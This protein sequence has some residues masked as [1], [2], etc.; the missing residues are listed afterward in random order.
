MHENEVKMVSKMPNGDLVS[1]KDYRL[2]VTEA[3]ALD[4][5]A[6]VDKQP[7]NYVFALI[8]QTERQTKE[9]E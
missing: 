1:T 4:K 6:K 7:A 8:E 5:Q 9:L 3:V 2:L